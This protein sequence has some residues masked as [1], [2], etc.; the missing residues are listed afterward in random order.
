[1]DINF[2]PERGILA[3]ETKTSLLPDFSLFVLKY[4]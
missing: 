1:M 4:L 2:F 3:V